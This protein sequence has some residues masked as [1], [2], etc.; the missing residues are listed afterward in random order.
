MYKFANAVLADPVFRRDASRVERNNAMNQS[1]NSGSVGFCSAQHIE[2][3]APVPK[4]A[5]NV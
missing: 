5:E 4:M 3:N 1:H 2:V